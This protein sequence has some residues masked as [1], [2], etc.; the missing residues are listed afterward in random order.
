MTCEWRSFPQ[1]GSAPARVELN[2]A[3]RPR[4][5]DYLFVGWVVFKQALELPMRKSRCLGEYLVLF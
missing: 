1:D 2:E 5:A 3:H 4:L